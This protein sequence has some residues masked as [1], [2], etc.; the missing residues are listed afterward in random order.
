MSD[1]LKLSFLLLVSACPSAY[2]VLDDG[3]ADSS[4]T[5][6]FSECGDGV[7]QPPEEC[8]DGNLDDNDQCTHKCTNSI[9]SDGI[10]GPDEACDDAN[11]EDQDACTNACTAAT[12]GD[13]IVGPGEACDDAN[14]NNDDG[15]NTSCGYC[16]D[17]Y[18]DSD[19]EECDNGN[20]NS[21]TNSCTSVCKIAS[22]GDGLVQNGVE[23]CDDGNSDEND[24]CLS[25][26]TP[27]VC[28]DG[29]IKV[30]VEECD[31]PGAF[32]PTAE[33]CSDDC[34]RCRFVFATSATYYGNLDSPGGYDGAISICENHAMN[35]G[36]AN[37]QAYRPWL[38]DDYGSPA[39][40][41]L[42]DSFN[43]LYLRIDGEIIASGWSDLTD[44]QLA[45][46]INIS[47]TGTGLGYTFAWTG[48]DILGYQSMADPCNDFNT[49][50]MS[51]YGSAGRTNVTD[52]GWTE[53]ST[54][55]CNNQFGLYCFEDLP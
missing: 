45:S 20:T 39:S 1:F 33:C 44:G 18:L 7:L 50:S 46:P 37:P 30:G 8:D 38:S 22:C 29:Y 13:G 48:T 12:C 51:V 23:D 52:S 42:D 3:P 40:S 19:F 17:D 27:A 47:E 16:G 55:T 2:S 41:R 21:D 6:P 10:V 35:A 4:T 14:E 32:D 15:C 53:Y 26:C 36:L 9:C 43:G 49:T 5:E 28:G 54:Y 31:D 25:D 24:D 34:K 11:D